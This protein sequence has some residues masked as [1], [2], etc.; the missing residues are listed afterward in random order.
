VDSNGN[1]YFPDVQNNRV[2]KIDASGIISTVAGNGTLGF[3]GDGSPA[4]ASRIS[5]PHGL[6]IESSGN[7]YIADQQNH[8]IRKVTTEGI[9]STF[10]GNGSQ[11]FS[12]DGGQAALAQFNNPAHVIFDS[13]GNLYIADGNNY[14]I[15]KVMANGIITTVV[16]S[17]S[18]GYSGDGGPATS[19][20]ITWIEGMA[21]DSAGNLYIANY[22][23]HR[24]RKVDTS[25]IIT[26]VAGTGTKGYSGDGGPATAAT[27]SSPAGLAVDSAG[28]LYIGDAGNNVVRKVTAAGIISTF[29]GNGTAG[30]SG[31]GGLA[32]AASLRGLAMYTS[33]PLMGL[34]F[35]SDNNLLIGDSGNGAVRKVTPAGI[36]S[37]IV[38]NG[39]N[40]Y[41]GNGGIATAAQISLPED[42][43]VDSAGNLFIAETG[44]YRIRKVTSILDCSS[45]AVSAGGVAACRTAGTNAATRTGYSKLT[46]NS[47]ATPYGTGVFSFKQNGVTVSEAGVPASPPTTRARIFIDYRASVTAI[48]GQSSSGTININTGLSIVNQG[49]ATASVEYALRNLNGDLLTVGRG[50]ITKDNH[51]ACFINQLQQMAAPDFS[52]PLNFQINTQFATLEIASDQPLSVVALR[53]TTNQR[54]EALF[55]TTPVADM[56]KTLTNTSIYF[57]QFADGGGYT[58]SL[59]LLNTSTQAETG[60]LQIFDN[61]G[62]PL[63]VNQVGGITSYS[64]QYTIPAGGAYHFQSD[65]LS[66]APSGWVRIVPGYS[67]MTPVGSGVFSYNPGSVLVSES[68]I[69]SSVSTTHARVYVDRSGGHNVGL[70]IANVGNTEANITINSYQTDGVSGVGTS[71]GPLTLAAYGHDAEFADQLIE[72]LPTGYRGVLDINSTTPFA[73]LTVRSLNNERGDFLMTTFPIA[74]AN[75]TAPS[76]VVFPHVADGGGYMT[77]F[78]LISAGGAASTTPGFYNE[79]GAPADFSH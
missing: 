46:V 59:I 29:A 43:V 44:N 57:P 51:I 34:V 48:P 58:T 63:I 55:T 36:I 77:E 28:N 41:S 19:A 39:F 2:R 27:L 3:G 32:T 45:L 25:G 13:A 65:G 14:R 20:A 10:A 16:G 22:G 79:A 74:D 78:M 23:T 76:P 9:I 61:N 64:F 8:R 71:K 24:V 73:A 60:S 72:G 38:G 49:S 42:M 35:D 70:A 47:G 62:N 6:A 7:L 30:F 12:G 26:T 68:G 56:T 67:S 5:S 40:G 15:R 37:T 50:A 31:D 53:M 11:G 4:T 21:F 69:P 54:G 33:Q 1:L 17:G 66:S 52:L 18:Q 75:Q